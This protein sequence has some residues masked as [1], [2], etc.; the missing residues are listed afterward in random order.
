MRCR[1][2]VGLCVAVM[3]VVWA[4]SALADPTAGPRICSSA[5]TALN[6]GYYNLTVDGNAYVPAGGA[7]TVTGDLTIDAGACL[8]AFSTATVTVFGNIKVGK[9]ATLALGCTPQSIGPVPPCGV[10]T[11]HDRVVGSI[12]ADH[13]LTMYIDGDLIEGDLISN[14]GGPGMTLSPY[15]NFPIKDNTIYGN[16]SITGWSGAWNGLLRNTIRGNATF[17]N[18]S[19]ITLGDDGTPDSSEVVDNTIWGSLTCS[20][21]WP[22]AQIGDSGGG[23]N[24]VY[25]GASGECATE[26]QAVGHALFGQM[27][28]ANSG[29]CMTLNYGGVLYGTTNRADLQL[30][31]GTYFFSFDDDSAGHDFVLRSCVHATAPCTAG[32]GPVTPL[33]NLP[34]RTF[35]GNVSVT[36]N[37]RP[38][39]YRIFCDVGNGFHENHGMY[40]DF[41]VYG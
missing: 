8:D 36:L 28:Q 26:S 31:K 25:G 6:G 19:G 20:G 24:I 21:N 39:T 4:G 30:A 16:V 9:G 14:G 15:V 5:G 40:V 13:P 22:I 37:L 33:T 18:N 10:T 2:L 12:T 23:D 17:A 1:L 35:V 29:L 41:E 38:G 11:T 7:L 27:C 3:G 34:D 32:M